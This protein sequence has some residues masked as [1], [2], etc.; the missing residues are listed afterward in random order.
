MEGILFE[1]LLPHMP[2]PLLSCMEGI[3]FEALLPRMRA[4]KACSSRLCFFA[5][6]HEGHPLRSSASSHA[7]MEGIHF[8]TTEDEHLEALASITKA[9]V[10]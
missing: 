10:S 9:G 6:G 7:G 8:E 5:C 4:W 2:P 1:A 3:L